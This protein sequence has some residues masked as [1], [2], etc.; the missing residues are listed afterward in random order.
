MAQAQP[1]NALAFSSL[2]FVQFKDEV[3]KVLA[4]GTIPSYTPHGESHIQGV[5]AAIETLT[6][7]ID[8]TNPLT[9]LEKLLLRFC[10]WSHD[11][12]MIID[13]AHLYQK[14]YHGRPPG[15]AKLEELRKDHDKASAFFLQRK[16]PSLFTDTQDAIRHEN[17]KIAAGYREYL[18]G[19]LQEKARFERDEALNLVAFFRDGGTRQRWL[20][21]AA[22]V[23]NTINLIARY[24]RRAESIDAAPELRWFLGER[25]RVQLLAAIFRL[26]D[27]LHVDR[28]RFEQTGFE[29]LARS[30][31]FSDES[32]VHW[33]KSFIVSAI[34][35]DA[36][37]ATVHVQSDVPVASELGGD[38]FA[39]DSERMRGM[40]R[41]I[42]NDLTE[43]V[44]SVGRILLK[45][46][47]PPLLGVTADVHEIPAMHYPHDV[48][49][50]LNHIYASSS[51]NTSRLITIALDVL[52]WHLR[53]AEKKGDNATYLLE[54]LEEQKKSLAEQLEQ[55]PCHEALRKVH[56][57]LE[58]VQRTWNHP[59]FQ[60]RGLAELCGERHVLH[61]LLEG[62]RATVLDKR[63]EVSDGAKDAEF[64]KIFA[65][66]TDIILYGYSDQVLTLLGRLSETRDDLPNVHVLECRTKTSYAPAGDLLYLDGERYA[67]ALRKQ[68]YRGT[69]MIEPDAA[70]G[71][72]VTE[73]E[74]PLVLLGSNAVYPG[75]T[76]VH[77]MGHLTVAAAA[78]AV[79]LR[80]ANGVDKCKVVVLT[81]TMKIGLIRDP[82]LRERHPNTWLTTQ[83]EVIARL[84]ESNIELHNWQ[85]DTVP[86]ELIDSLLV[87]DKRKTLTDATY[88]ELETLRFEAAQIYCKNLDNRLLASFLA[89]RHNELDAE[90]KAYI[91]ERGKRRHDID[92]NAGN[93]IVAVAYGSGDPALP[94]NVRRW[95]DNEWRARTGTM[96]NRAREIIL[97]EYVNLSTRLPLHDEEDEPQ[98]PG[99]QPPHDSHLPILPK[100]PA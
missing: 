28:T 87:L 36:E 43:D 96:I 9:P 42:V 47:F 77:S 78:K 59:H 2:L 23:A 80:D 100:V 6:S 93:W 31:Q 89:F 56:D 51:P 66:R 64:Q 73:R 94:E 92:W 79:H 82:R 46:G 62:V 12:G 25:I 38:D 33:I 53:E 1:P 54:R 99:T 32:R 83:K 72:I 48:R 70:V 55:R 67:Q 44:L 97:Q 40:I 60:R 22:T 16:I 45:A 52:Q 84:R 69:V 95:L 50:A 21:N 91:R 76:F 65:D 8:A 85:E 34:R 68:G 24:H 3:D 39:V 15:A 88:G 75:G 29:L 10:A 41:F 86:S 49:A 98:A 58:A 13:V 26:A 18:E 63:R 19:K 27:A 5:E 57:L 35:I 14:D 90:V 4:S 17:E 11:L 37:A 30:P 61:T 81:D 7:M 20:A 74:R 71:R